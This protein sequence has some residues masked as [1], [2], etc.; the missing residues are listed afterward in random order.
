MLKP[1]KAIAQECYELYYTSPWSNIPQNSRCTATSNP[2]LKPFESDEQDMRYTAYEF[3]SD[4]LLLPLDTDEQV[5]DN[6]LEHIYNSSVRTQ[7][8]V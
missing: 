1:L 8:V 5:L 3:I 6:K 7:D 2:S 4:V